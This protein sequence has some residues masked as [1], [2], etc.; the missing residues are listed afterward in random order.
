MKNLLLII[1]SLHSGNGSLSI[2]CFLGEVMQAALPAALKLASETRITLNHSADFDKALLSDKEF[3]ILDALELHSELRV[4][5]VSKLLGQKTVF[6]LLRSLFE[7]N[8]IVIS[9]EITEK[10][11]PRK[12]SFI[13]LN[14]IYKDSANRKILFDVLERAPKQLELLLA[15]FKLEKYQAEI[16]KADLIETSGSSAAVLKTLL[17]KEIFAQ[18]DKIVSRLSI[19]EMET[20][21]KF[22]LNVAQEN[23]LKQVQSEFLLNVCVNI[24]EIRWES[25]IP[26]SM[27]QNGPKSGKRCSRE[28]IK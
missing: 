20:F 3:L 5:D 2:I 9:E 4:S 7:K 10:F 28:S 8:I 1:F 26:N 21:L 11:K 18:E 12:K 23:A 27:I 13:L 25:T 22:E 17:D 14:P 15:Y 19:E 6:P 24:L 16:S